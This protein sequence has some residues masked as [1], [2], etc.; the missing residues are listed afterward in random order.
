MN[1]EQ[2]QYE[3]K[4][5]MLADIEKSINDSHGYAILLCTLDEN[6]EPTVIVAS[7]TGNAKGIEFHSMLDVCNSIIVSTQDFA[8]RLLYNVAKKSEPDSPITMDDV[9]RQVVLIM[10]KA[11]TEGTNCLE[12][13]TK[14][15]QER[16]EILANMRPN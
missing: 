3:H 7:G 9:L 1:I 13:I 2:G 15:R 16:L 6:K 10:L 12:A 8:A 11:N 4:N 5:E 14:M